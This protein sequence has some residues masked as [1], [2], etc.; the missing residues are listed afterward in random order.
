MAAQLNKLGFDVVQGLDRELQQIGDVQAEFEDKLRTKPEVALLFYAGHGLQVDGRNYLIPIDA[1]I[2]QKAH[3]ASRA[4]LFNY[5][6]GEMADNASASLIFLD[7]CRDNPFTRNLARSLGESARYAG[8]RG[9]LARIEKVAGTF[10]AYATAPDQVAFDGKGQ[11]SP[12]TSALLQHIE[13]PGLSVGDLMI[14]VRNKVLA[15]TN[16]RQ[17]P[18]DQSSLRARFYFVPP[19]QAK[20]SAVSEA[21]SEWAAIQGTISL[22]VL[23]AFQER[24]PDPPWSTYAEARANEVRAADAARQEAEEVER[25]RLENLRKNEEAVLRMEASVLKM[26]EAAIIEK[27][28]LEHW[29]AIKKLNDPAK[30]RVFLSEYGESRYGSLAEEEL[31][32]LATLAWQKVDKSNRQELLWFTADYPGTREVVE[33][34]SLFHQVRAPR[35]EPRPIDGTKRV[36]FTIRQKLTLVLLGILSAGLGGGAVLFVEHLATQ[37]I[38]DC[39]ECPELVRVPEGS[40]M[41]GSPDSE[42]GRRTDEGPQRQVTIA[43]PFAAGKFEVTF[44]EWDACVSAGGCTGKVNDNGWGR[45][46]RPVINVT[47][48]DAQEYVDWLS[49]KTEKSYRLLTEAEWEYAAR[50]GTT[51]P[52]S[53]GTTIS[54]DQANFKGL[55]TFGGSAAGTFREMTVEVGSFKPNAFGL[56]DMHGNVKE[57][58]QDC[59][60]ENYTNVTAEGSAVTASDCFPR[61][62]RGGSWFNLAVDLRS[63]CRNR[64]LFPGPS[65]FV[66]FRVAR[67]L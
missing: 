3:L 39:P 40:F 50:A 10:I 16:G 42:E 58:V 13:T 14:D 57:M 31:Q 28:A 26:S 8:V 7:A 17:E 64:V 66:G 30:L 22:A 29:R 43:K 21:A 23:A 27:A 24:H 12:F 47:W 6:L 2:T 9:G 32:K 67:T 20:P 44:D 55:S 46:K 15:E 49:K 65:E 35:D 19:E 51:T 25:E 45:G 54:T 18:W 62:L 56:F 59:Y 36:G 5:I 4:V 52:F 61:V 37:S 11:N 53:T 38:R 34:N 63:A 1:E 41:M 60:V 33:A 48:S